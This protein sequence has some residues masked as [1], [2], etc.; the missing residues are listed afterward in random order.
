MP[1]ARRL[2][3]IS[4]FLYQQQ[5]QRHLRNCFGAANHSPIQWDVEEIQ[6]SPCSAGIFCLCLSLQ[7]SLSLSL[8]VSRRLSA[9]TRFRISR[10]RI[11]T[12]SIYVH[13]LG[14]RLYV[15]CWRCG[16]RLFV[17]MLSVEHP[18]IMIG[19]DRA[20][21]PNESEEVRKGGSAQSVVRV[22]HHP[23]LWHNRQIICVM[24]LR[25]SINSTW[26]ASWYTH[27]GRTKPCPCQLLERY[28]RCRIHR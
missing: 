5:T 4:P 19:D 8:S 17:W 22:N 23:F 27:R 21:L 20:V 26:G 6:Y 24:I 13:L 3:H 16:G 14:G 12:T 1:T 11:Y 28:P 15:H 10:C 7:V 18:I 9:A 2:L 25:T